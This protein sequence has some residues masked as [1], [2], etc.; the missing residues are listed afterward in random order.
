MDIQQLKYFLAI[1]DE[2]GMSYAAKKL[3]M[4]QPP[5][6]KQLNNLENELGCALF[7]RK[8]GN[9]TL[10]EKG[11]LLYE[12]AKLLLD[13]FQSIEQIF[14]DLRNNYSDELTLG[15][16]TTPAILLVPVLLQ[17]F[18]RKSPDTKLTLIED[19]NS[20][21][22]QMINNDQLNLAL[23]LEPHDLS[24]YNYLYID[25][26]LSNHLHYQYYALGHQ[27][28]LPSS[29]EYVSFRELS[30]HPLIIHKSQEAFVSNLNRQYNLSL[31]TFYTNANVMTSIAWCRSKLGVAIIPHASVLV[32]SKYLDS[33]H[34]VVRPIRGY[35]AM[36]ARHVLLWKKEKILPHAPQIFTNIIKRKLNNVSSASTNGQKCGQSHEL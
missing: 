18:I 33:N 23:V 22:I 36:P 8:K 12:Y 3:Q 27:D 7:T 24:P 9:Y 11:K 30:E 20:N 6:T 34:L 21:L 14:T 25:E 17:E 4:T 19:T 28:M 35:P 32:A 10:T 5:L 13:E 26:L 15:T 29:K 16:T 2:H 1:A 31:R